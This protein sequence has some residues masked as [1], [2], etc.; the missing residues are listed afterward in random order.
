MR[1]NRFMCVYRVRSVERLTVGRESFGRGLGPGGAGAAPPSH[2]AAARG[3]SS[4]QGTA[5]AE[6]RGV[7]TGDGR[8]S[9]AASAA[10]AG[11]RFPPPSGVRVRAATA[12]H[13]GQQTI[14]R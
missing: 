6:A 5:A 11:Q 12:V 14:V 13:G 1:V 2:V 4:P 10:D 7:G 9:A 8:V 3:R